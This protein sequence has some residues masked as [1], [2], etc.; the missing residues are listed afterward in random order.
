MKMRSEWLYECLG[1]Q[2]GCRDMS[3]Y[4]GQCDATLGTVEP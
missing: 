2:P 3:A 1:L 4:I